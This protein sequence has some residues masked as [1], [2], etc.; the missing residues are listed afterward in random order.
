MQRKKYFWKYYCIEIISKE[1]INKQKKLNDL[2]SQPKSKKTKVKE[3][4]KNEIKLWIMHELP[5]IY[6][7]ECSSKAQKKIEQLLINNNIDLLEYNNY[8]L[9]EN[10]NFKKVNY[11]EN[12]EVN[13]L[14]KKIDKKYHSE[15][16]KKL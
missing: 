9:K 7:N 3:K 6:K 10:T 1:I 14:M 16:A 4:E 2:F 12:N 13:E 11:F 15:I 8:K 5:S